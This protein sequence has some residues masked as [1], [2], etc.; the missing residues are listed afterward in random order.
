M[1]AEVTWQYLYWNATLNY[2]CVL[3]IAILFLSVRLPSFHP[4]LSDG[5]LKTRMTE[6]LLRSKG[7]LGDGVF[8]EREMGTKTPS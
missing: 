2:S 5:C 3:F 1:R 4:S 8:S 7:I 6:T